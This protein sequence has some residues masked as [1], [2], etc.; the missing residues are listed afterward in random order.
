MF[1]RL[2]YDIQFQADASVPMIAH[3][4][5]HPSRELDLV[6]PDSLRVD[7][8]VEVEKYVDSFGT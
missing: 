3:L 8:A 7:P 1:I 5:I 6:E 2:G 4:N